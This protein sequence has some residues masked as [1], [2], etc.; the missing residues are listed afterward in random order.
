MSTCSTWPARAPRTATGPVQICPGTILRGAR[1]GQVLQ[2]DILAIEPAV[3]WGYN[4]IRPLAGAL[5]HDF[6]ETR[7]IHIALDRANKA[8]RLPWGQDVPLK[9]F[10]GVMG[11][12]PPKNWGVI[13]TLPP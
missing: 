9:P 8:W 13:S 3:D 5:P 4:L 10:F 12:A 1:A 7:M 2:V 6:P 11:T